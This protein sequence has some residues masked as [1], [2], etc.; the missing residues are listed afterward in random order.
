MSKRFAG[1]LMAV[2]L[3]APPAWAQSAGQS[4]QKPVTPKP[5]KTIPIAPAKPDAA[6]PAATSGSPRDTVAA[7]PLADRM[8]LQSDL[9]WT[10]DYNGLVE[11]EISERTI[12]AIR[13]FQKRRNT[14]ET[15]LLDAPERTAL[16]SAAKTQQ[17]NVGW[18]LADDPMTGARL[19]LP[20]KLAPI[21]GKSRT[22]SRWKSV[23]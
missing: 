13:A 19:G 7:L 11:G 15:G 23:V 6:K 2:L 22:G 9:V 14:R 12:A 8:A 5:I 1:I 3:L 17:T 20:E 10:G 21:T 16:G 18:R 4:G